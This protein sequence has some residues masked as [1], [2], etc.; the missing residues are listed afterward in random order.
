MSFLPRKLKLDRPGIK[1]LFSWKAL[2]IWLDKLVVALEESYQLQRDFVMGNTAGETSNW[3]IR[4]ATA[5]DVTANQARAVGNLIV[6]NKTTG[7][8]WEYE[9]S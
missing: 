5:A 7:T 9:A 4:E 8:K 2:Q 6:V 3:K 1:V